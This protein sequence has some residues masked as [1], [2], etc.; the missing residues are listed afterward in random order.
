MKWTIITVKCCTWLQVMISSIK[1]Y[2][3]ACS[4]FITLGKRVLAINLNTPCGNFHTG[5]KHPGYNDANCANLSLLRS[6]SQ[7]FPHL[8]SLSLI[9]HLVCNSEYTASCVWIYSL[10]CS[11]W[12]VSKH[13][14]NYMLWCECRGA[15]HS[16]FNVHIHTLSLNYTLSKPS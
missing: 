12:T 14:H 16:G 7:Q 3:T 6:L 1:T 15:K 2:Y 11:I 8:P 4:L 10:A 13:W 9:L 5:R